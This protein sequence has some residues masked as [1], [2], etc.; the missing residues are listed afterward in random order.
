MCATFFLGTTTNRGS[1]SPNTFRAR[2]ITGD[3]LRPDATRCIRSSDV[4]TATL[5]VADGIFI[6]SGFTYSAPLF[7]NL[8]STFSRRLSTVF[9]QQF[10]FVPCRRIAY[11]AKTHAILEQFTIDLPY[12]CFLRHRLNLFKKHKHYYI[13][14]S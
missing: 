5:S 7:Q 2:F 4:K 12:T 13:Y 14:V 10:S 11:G 1:A 9:A 3:I 8:C 6:S